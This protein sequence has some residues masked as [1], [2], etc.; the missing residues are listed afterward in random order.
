MTATQTIAHALQQV[1]APIIA[2]LAQIACG[3]VSDGNLISKDARSA[4]VKCGYVENAS[5]WNFLTADGVRVC[6]NLGILNY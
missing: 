2:Q 4:L 3:H 1:P 6:A 5:G